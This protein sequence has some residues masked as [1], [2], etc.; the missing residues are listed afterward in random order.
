MSD[1]YIKPEKIFLIYEKIEDLKEEG[2]K[3]ESFR[4]E[5]VSLTSN[6]KRADE[7]VKKNPSNLIKKV[8]ELQQELIIEKQKFKLHGGI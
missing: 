2:D 1:L 8:L 3:L 7:E 5:L 4:Y 6:E